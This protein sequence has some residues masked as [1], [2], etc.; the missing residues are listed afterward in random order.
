MDDLFSTNELINNILNNIIEKIQTPEINLKIQNELINPLTKLLI[1]H[2]YPY[3]I[4]TVIIVFLMF[5]CIIGTFILILSKKNNK[6]T[7]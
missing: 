4:T 5:I 3:L 2:M 7:Y 6:Y 1:N